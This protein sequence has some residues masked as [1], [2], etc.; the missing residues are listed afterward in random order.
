V[1]TILRSNDS[2][3]Y[4]QRSLVATTMGCYKTLIGPRLRARGCEPAALRPNRPKLP[5]AWRC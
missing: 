2:A 4:G 5:S 3:T 1:A